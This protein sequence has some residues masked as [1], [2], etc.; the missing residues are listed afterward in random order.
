MVDR[1]PLV[2]RRF[3]DIVIPYLHEGIAPLTIASVNGEDGCVEVG[4]SAIFSYFHLILVIGDDDHRQVRD[5]VFVEVALG[6]CDMPTLR[7]QVL[8]SGTL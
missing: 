8:N 3:Q 1:H 4:G 6:L 5:A 2:V 7:N